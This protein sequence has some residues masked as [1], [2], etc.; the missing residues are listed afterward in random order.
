MLNAPVLLK[1]ADAAALKKAPDARAV[2]GEAVKAVITSKDPDL[3][4]PAQFAI[5]AHPGVASNAPPAA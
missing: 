2:F 1:R 5:T 3:S 4:K